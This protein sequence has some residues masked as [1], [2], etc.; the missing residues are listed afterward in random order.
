MTDQPS[1]SSAELFGSDRMWGLKELPLPEPVSWWPQ[2]PGWYLLGTALL[3]VLVWLGWKLWLRY[4]RNS[5]R[6]EGMARLNGM[7]SDPQALKDLPFLLRRSAL[8]A[9]PRKDV[10]SLRGDDWLAW[11]DDSAGRKLFEQTDAEALDELSFA[12]ENDRS[13]DDVSAQRLIEASKV[14]MRSH[15]AAI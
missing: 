6:R 1:E 14:W 8:Q 7:A 4:Q 2:T 5:Y 13:L 11:L 15:R 12:G 3:L 9:A 10:A